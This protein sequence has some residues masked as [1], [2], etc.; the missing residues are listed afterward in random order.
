MISSVSESRNFGLIGA[1][2]V[3]IFLSYLL[4]NQGHKVTLYEAGEW[5]SESANLNLH[6][7]IFRTKSKI[8]DGA[9]RVGGASNLWKRR[10]SEFSSVAFNRLDE[11]KKREWPIGLS[12]L[13][14]ANEYLFSLLHESGLRDNEYIE[15]YF[16]KIVDELPKP[17]A[18]TLFRFCDENFF[19]DLLLE[20]EKNTNFKLLTGSF[21]SEIRLPYASKLQENNVELV[22]ADTNCESSKKYFHSEVVLTGGCLQSTALAMNSP[23]IIRRLSAPNLVGKYLMEHFDG[24]IGTLKIKAKNNPFMKNL[25]LDEGR[26]I[27]GEEFGVGLTIQ[28]EPVRNQKGVDF[29]LELVQWRKTYLFDPNLNIFNR[30][31]LEIYRTL[32]LAER[33]LK[34]IPSELRKLWFRFRSTDLYS[35][36]LKGE[37]IPFARSELQISKASNSGAIKLIYNHRVSSTSKNRMRQRLR[38]ISTF[39]H[40][41][42]FGRFR[43]HRYFRLNPLFYTGPNFHPMGSLRMGSDPQNSI[44]GPDFA[45]H[46]SPHVFALNSGVFPNG[47]NHNPTSMVLALAVIFASNFSK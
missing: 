45:F 42:N 17:F 27:P 46:G 30:M 23:E 10:V 35:V 19:V 3:G 18:L 41:N 14:K 6:N 2:P 20:L 24:Y 26:K 38:E 22:V 16:S 37:E 40:Q 33:T 32:F 29:H 7:Y 5:D 25:L 4:V 21:I 43:I 12:D 11:N 47:S 9:H 34:K 44:V 1:G 36:W 8:P 28:S 13:E 39:L 15:R 31:P